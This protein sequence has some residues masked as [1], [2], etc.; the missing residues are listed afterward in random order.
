MPM[1]RAIPLWICLLGG[2]VLG[3]A[4]GG[5][6]RQESASSGPAGADDRPAEFP[7]SEPG[8]PTSVPVGAVGDARMWIV[9]A[10]LPA[11][12]LLSSQPAYV[13]AFRPLTDAVAGEWAVYAAMDSHQIRYDISKAGGAVVHTQVRVFR[14]GKPLGEPALRD[15]QRDWDPLAAQPGARQ[16]RRTMTRRTIEAAGR[17]WDAMCYEDCWIDEGIH[18]V[19]KTWVSPQVPVFGTI[20]VELY[21][22]AVLEAQMEL[23]RFGGSG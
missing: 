20:R 18:Y 4:S 22:D 21:G 12:G 15:D 3:L 2:F 7:T 13:P 11:P 5:C 8:R 19:R 23:T 17:R 9:A 16:A 14:D 6:R 1:N 10:S